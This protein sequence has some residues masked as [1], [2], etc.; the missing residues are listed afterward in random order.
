[1]CRS[2]DTAHAPTL[3]GRQ[4]KTNLKVLLKIGWVLEALYPLFSSSSSSSSSALKVQSM[5]SRTK[6]DRPSFSFCHLLA[7][8]GPRDTC[9]ARPLEAMNSNLTTSSLLPVALIATPFHYRTQGSA[10]F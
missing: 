8:E 2:S 3:Q 9:L 5:Q 7:R 10:T 1:M 6:L 4:T